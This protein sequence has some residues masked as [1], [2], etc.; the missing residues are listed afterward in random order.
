MRIEWKNLS[1]QGDPG[2]TLKAVMEGK[3]LN[4]RIL[5]EATG[6]NLRFLPVCFEVTYFLFC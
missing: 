3:T 4:F 1:A 2:L 5:G 6:D